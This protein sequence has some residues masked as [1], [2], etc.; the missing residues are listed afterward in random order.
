MKRTSIHRGGA[1]SAEIAVALMA[2]FVVPLQLTYFGVSPMSIG[3]ALGVGSML[4]A[5][6]V[7]SRRN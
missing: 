3:I 1:L 4:G 2:C 5:T 6:Y 7:L